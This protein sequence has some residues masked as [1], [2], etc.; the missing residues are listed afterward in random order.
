MQMLFS[1]V[2]YIKEIHINYLIYFPMT[3]EKA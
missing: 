3:E 1:F 2:R